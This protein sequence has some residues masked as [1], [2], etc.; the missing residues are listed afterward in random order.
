MSTT[1]V[2]TPTPSTG[3]GAKIKTFFS[4]VGHEIVIIG[5][6]ALKE[7]GI[8]QK[9]VAFAEPLIIQTIQ[10][11]FP[12]AVIPT[13]KINAI[14]QSSLNVSSSIA[15][16][17]QAEGLNP[18]LDQTAAIQTAVALHALKVTPVAPSVPTT[19]TT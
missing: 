6:D 2:P 19:P 11:M 16:A 12:N 14:I 9:D 17:L 10:E 13:G 7:I 1:P 4:E 8:I 15:S 3:L 18:T 5:T